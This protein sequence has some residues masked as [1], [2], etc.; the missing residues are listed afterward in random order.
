MTLGPT[1]PDSANRRTRLPSHVI[2]STSDISCV[3]TDDGCGANRKCSPN[4]TASTTSPDTKACANG[5]RPSPRLQVGTMT[6]PTI[7]W[8]LSLDSGNSSATAYDPFRVLPRTRQ[9]DTGSRI[10]RIFHQ[11]ASC[12]CFGACRKLAARRGAGHRLANGP[13]NP[14]AC[15]RSDAFRCREIHR[16]SLGIW[17]E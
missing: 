7:F 11:H 14:P 8:V 2:F 15:S 5:T 10:R 16:P 3:A 12:A 13:R 1:L 17:P 4:A 6:Q 9:T